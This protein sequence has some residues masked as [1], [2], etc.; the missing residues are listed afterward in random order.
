M[1]LAH[2]SISPTR[3]V[4]VVLVQCC[5]APA[6]SCLGWT[7]CSVRLGNKGAVCLPQSRAADGVV[8]KTS[9]IENSYIQ[10]SSLQCLV[11]F[12][13]FPLMVVRVIRHYS[14]TIL[15]CPSLDVCATPCRGKMGDVCHP[16]MWLPL[17]CMVWCIEMDG[18]W[19]CGSPLTAREYIDAWIT[20][21]S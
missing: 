13:F 18:R 2:T 21:C 7:F 9:L 16:Y 20:V 12:C 1:Q 17:L 11:L 4:L 15:L 5:R 14:R 6:A 3:S 8:P 19:M 10:R